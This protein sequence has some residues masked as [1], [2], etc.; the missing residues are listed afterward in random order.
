VNVRVAAKCL[1][2]A[3][4]VLSGCDLVLGIDDVSAANGPDSGRMTQGVAQERDSSV[5]PSSSA[6]ASTTAAGSAGR[7]GEAGQQPVAAPHDGGAASDAA[8]DG[9]ATSPA[10]PVADPAADGGE[11]E[12][13]GAG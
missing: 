8:S 1:L 13:A 10:D 7:T 11:N 2:G 9:P 12:D 3:L 6:D 4:S 5:A